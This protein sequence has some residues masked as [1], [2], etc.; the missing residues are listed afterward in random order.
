VISAA[1]DGT[2]VPSGYPCTI[3]EVRLL[4]APGSVGIWFAAAAIGGSVVVTALFTA[5]ALLVG[6]WAVAVLR[7]G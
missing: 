5:G 6:A 7:E 4:V 2:P 1:R 3:E